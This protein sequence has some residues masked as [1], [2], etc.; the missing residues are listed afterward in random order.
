VI[1]AVLLALSALS[2]FIWFHLT[3]FRGG[4]WKSDQRLSEV[5][6]MDR[7]PAVVTVIP[8]R[9]EAETIAITVN[10]LLEQQYKGQLHIIVVDDNSDDATAEAAG[11]HSNLK[12]IRGKPLQSGWTGKLWAVH[13]GLEEIANFA[14][15]AEYVLLTDADIAH[16]PQNLELLVSKA[17]KSK[18]GLVSLM[19]ALRC[20][21][22]WER[23][24]I[25]AFV[26]FFQKLYPFR[27]VNRPTHPMA[28]AA[29]GCMLVHLPT[30]R[31]VGGIEPIKDRLIDD[32]A[33]GALIKSKSAIWLGVSTQT[34][35]LRAYSSLSDIWQMVART[36]F[37][38]L[39]HS[40]LALLGTVMAMVVVYLVP[41]S[42]FVYGLWTS[43]PL[44]WITAGGA[45]IIM[46]Q[47]YAPTLRLY[48]QPFLM[49]FSL[50]VAGFVYTLMTLSSALSHWRGRGGAWKGRSYARSDHK[51]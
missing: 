27:L 44:L 25:P 41:P 38:Q 22:F 11:A 19:V 30:L 17:V 2:L 47:L 29:G 14:P 34:R 20:E 40:V 33:M 42:L 36:A 12:V 9:N 49:A 6:E 15:K 21:S 28:A 23:L 26:Y 16:H 13:Q 48:K 18:R 5:F 43:D 46:A 45:Y 51:E 50:P 3:Y 32:C 1:D 4:F 39:N 8:A 37:V 7:W 31:E 10:S 35:S 24:L